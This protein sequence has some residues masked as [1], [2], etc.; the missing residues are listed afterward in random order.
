M[1]EEREKEQTLLDDTLD[2]ID[3][4]PACVIAFV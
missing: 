1:K 2:A 4:L 3:A